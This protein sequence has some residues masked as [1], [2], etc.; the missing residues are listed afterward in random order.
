ML[1]LTDQRWHGFAANYTDGAQGGAGLVGMG[2]CRDG[3]ETHP[4]R[5][6]QRPMS[7]YVEEEMNSGKVKYIIFSLATAGLLLLVLYLLL[8]GTTQVARAGAGDLFVTPTGGGDCSQASPCDFQSALGLAAE[9]D[10]IY[11]A[12]GTYTGA[13]GAVVTVTHSLDLYGGWDGA[14][15]GPVT[16]DPATYSST[17]DGQ[18]QRRVIYIAPGT[19]V[20]LDGLRIANG[21]VLT[22]GPAARKGA[23]LYARD[24][25]LILREMTFENNVI[26][27]FDL[28]GGEYAWG[29]GAMVEGGSLEI[30]TST[31]RGN[32][33][34]AKKDSSGGGLVISRT[35]SATVVGSLFQDNDAWHASGLYFL[36]DS[37]SPLLVRNCDFVRNGQGHSGYAYGG[38][39]GALEV[40]RG[41]AQIEGNLITDSRAANDYGGLALYYSAA[42]LDGN[43][44]YNNQ[45]ARTS[46][47]YLSSV[48][49]LTVTNNI[50]AGNRSNYS[51]LL[52]SAVRVRGG[53]GQF[54]HNTIARNQS[55]YGLLA[56]N[57]A[58]ITLTNTI[59]VSHTMG[60]SVTAGSSVTLE[61]TLWGGGIW[62][63]GD[64]WGGGG[65]IY[66]GALNIWGDPAF[67]HPD[68]GD[69]HIRASST[70]RNAGVDAG[71]YHDIDGDPRP[72]GFGVDIGADE[73]SHWG[74]YLPWVV[75]KEP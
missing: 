41:V 50:I 63:N 73:F 48:A 47:L 2:L 25:D 62:A 33:A 54:M 75:R 57:D 21:S 28:P 36:G 32:G 43:L 27:I 16:R 68:S 37:E 61:A 69:Y 4:Y 8:P 55:T 49:P 46:G 42:T 70:A 64:D 38:Y 9:G 34:W 5:T 22:A 20:T 17:L 6:Y 56:E 11:L 58:S 3:S 52:T 13:G 7:I 14:P 51:W 30:Y 12:T 59:L 19:S 67:I 44:I 53:S 35:L 65:A 15:T 39:I 74:L 18:N 1:A 66:T 71:V 26:D 23:G 29:A 60:I 72:V 10:S 45:S 31:F 24:A 40:V